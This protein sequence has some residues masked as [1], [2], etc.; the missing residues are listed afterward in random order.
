MHEVGVDQVERKATSQTACGWQY[1]QRVGQA[2][3]VVQRIAGSGEE[4]WVPHFDGAVPPMPL[5]RAKTC[6]LLQ[7]YE[8]WKRGCVR[9]RSY[10]LDVCDRS[11]GLGE[12]LRPQPQ[13]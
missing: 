2:L 3:H 5:D 1:R 11:Q 9:H 10:D 13:P 8:T 6:V 4:P 12:T 7:A